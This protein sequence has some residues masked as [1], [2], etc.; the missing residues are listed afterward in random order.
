MVGF[1]SPTKCQTYCS[2]SDKLGADSDRSF[3]GHAVAHTLKNMRC[4]QPRSAPLI[5]LKLIRFAL[6]EEERLKREEE[7]RL[8]AEVE[9]VKKKQLERERARE[10]RELE[11]MVVHD[12]DI[13]E[14]IHLLIYNTSFL[15]IVAYRS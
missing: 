4:V 5:P 13:S 8:E 11:R 1:Y 7:E 14:N 9:A 3:I 10:A 2:Y 15:H 12:E 6:E